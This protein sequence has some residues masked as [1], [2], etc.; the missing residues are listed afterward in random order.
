MFFLLSLA[1][2]GVA[3]TPAP[4]LTTL[5]GHIENALATDSIHL[6]VGFKDTTIAVN[7][8][9][10]FFCKLTSL[11][12]PTPTKFEYGDHQTQLYFTP[13][14]QV[15]MRVDY[16]Q[17]N[18]S[19][20]YRGRGSTVNDYL[21]QSDY[22]FEYGRPA[23]T[24]RTS[25]FPKGTPADARKAADSLRQARRDFLTAYD[26]AHPLPPVFVREQQIAVD[27]NWATQQ[28]GYAFKHPADTM[29]ASY[30]DFMRQVP[31][32]EV[33]RLSS[34][35]LIDN[36][37]L[38]NLVFGYPVRLAPQG[39]LSLDALQGKRIYDTATQ[40]LGNG[41][42]RKW[43]IELLFQRNLVDSADG[44][45]VFYQSFKRVNTDST[46]AKSFRESLLVVEKLKGKP[47]PAFTL[48]DRDNK[49]VSVSDFRGKVVYLDFWGTWCAPCMRELKEYAPGLRQ[50]LAHQDVV[51]LYVSVGDAESK[52]LK[53]I[54]DERFT[55][56]NSIHLHSPNGQIADLYKVD[57]F[58]SYFII[59]RNGNIIQSYA[60]RPS[61][62]DT[63]SKALDEA[64]KQ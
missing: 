24:L 45:K 13:G 32:G 42:A 52:W 57:S 58:P 59:G 53:T 46:L 55:S 10:D 21:A 51:F 37:R 43:A 56:F 19:L 17:F 22:R 34:R 36:S 28:L 60:A 30:F 33:E 20:T 8:R 4:A 25:G 48:L 64:L 12:Q 40:E 14:D 27:C 5:R 16:Q 39:K 9:G 2:G 26:K 41:R 7:K 6:I 44:A 29:P 63:I 23:G 35:G 54:A 1:L 49:P 61:D 62:T 50:K 47:A 11:K 15:V 31:V 18:K 3:Q 38:A